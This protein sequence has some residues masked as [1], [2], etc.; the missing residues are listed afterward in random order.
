M[1]KGKGNALAIN[2]AQWSLAGKTAVVTGGTK[3][4]GY[5]IVE[6]LCKFGATVHTCARQEADLLKCLREWEAKGF[7]VTGSTCDVSSPEDREKLVAE[8][9]SVFGGKLDILV[10]NAGTGFVKPM[11]LIISVQPDQWRDLLA[12]PEMKAKETNRIPL[13]RVGESEEVAQLVA[14]LCLPASRY[15]TGQVIF[16]DGGKS[17][18]GNL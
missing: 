17:I 9:S 6:E 2:D 11:A 8:V 4:I 3:G 16:I 5:S 13:G 12:M 15:I 10:N 1:E 18:N 14:F 7:K